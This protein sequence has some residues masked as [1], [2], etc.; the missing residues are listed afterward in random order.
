[1]SYNTLHVQT[2]MPSSASTIRHVGGIRD[3]QWEKGNS[4]LVCTHCLLLFVSMYIFSEL[5]PCCAR[6]RYDSTYMLWPVQAPLPL[7]LTPL[8]HK[9]LPRTLAGLRESISCRAPSIITE[10]KLSDVMLMEMRCQLK[11]GASCIRAVFSSNS[12]GVLCTMTARV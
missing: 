6:D 11:C 10:S 3:K 9:P 7:L 4:R 2:A 12:S 5:A 8:P 1:M